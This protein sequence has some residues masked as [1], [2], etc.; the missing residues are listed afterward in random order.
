MSAA[1][2]TADLGSLSN[3]QLQAVKQLQDGL[4]PTGW[5]GVSV[6]LDPW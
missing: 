2:T 1:I 6:Q 4:H 5:S 3:G